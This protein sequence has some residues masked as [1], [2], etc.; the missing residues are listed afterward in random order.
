MVAS[1]NARKS[2]RFVMFVFFHLFRR[3]VVST[4]SSSALSESSVP[5]SDPE[6]DR[7]ILVWWAAFGFTLFFRPAAE[8]VIRLVYFSICALLI[9]TLDGSI[10]LVVGHAVLRAAKYNGYEPSL[11]SS[12]EAG[13]LGGLIVIPPI[14]LATVSLIAL[15]GGLQLQKALSRHITFLFELAS[16]IAISAAACSV[17]VTIVQC[18][19]PDNGQPLDATHAARAGALGACILT[20]P[21]VSTAAFFMYMREAQT[22]SSARND[23]STP[24]GD[25]VRAFTKEKKTWGDGFMLTNFGFLCLFWGQVDAFGCHESHVPSSPRSRARPHVL[26]RTAAETAAYVVVIFCILTVR[27]LCF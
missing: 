15:L 20:V 4:P 27:L 10:N 11:L 6:K 9:G 13:S 3:Y 5:P 18:T 12:L 7:A 17:G 24:L 26:T 16:T 14:T 23:P 1:N 22:M 2:Q 19:R 21:I 8:L 25:L